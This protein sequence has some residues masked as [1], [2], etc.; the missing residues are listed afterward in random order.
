MLKLNSSGAYQWHTFSKP[1]KVNG[2]AVD[3]SGNVYVTGTSGPWGSPIN[4]YSG[5]GYFFVLKLNSS[6]IYQW[7]TFY[8]SGIVDSVYYGSAD[9]ANA[10]A[11]DGS[12]N[13]YVTGTSYGS[14]GYPINPHSG[15]RDIFVLKLNS[16]GTYQWNTFYGPGAG[17]NGF[18]RILF[19]N[20]IPCI[21]R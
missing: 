19:M 5:N 9:E 17:G 2:I 21:R 6:G 8:G 13:V 10:I 7:H 14:W 1:N 12:S 16:A 18:G 20:T 11:I 3:G 15:S 4:P